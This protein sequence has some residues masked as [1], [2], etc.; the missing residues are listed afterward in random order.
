MHRGI[1]NRDSR[2]DYRQELGNR[3][4]SASIN[5]NLDKQAPVRIG[6]DRRIVDVSIGVRA[7]RD[8]GL[9][10]PEVAIAVDI[11][12]GRCRSRFVHLETFL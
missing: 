10:E 2:L 5:P 9:K 1:V 12:L 3:I 11:G 6:R 7:R 4:A 8:F